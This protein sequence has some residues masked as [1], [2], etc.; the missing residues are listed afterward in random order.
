MNMN[1][2]PLSL[3]LNVRYDC[4]VDDMTHMG[5]IYSN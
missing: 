5:M 3:S 4:V 2:D 1:Y